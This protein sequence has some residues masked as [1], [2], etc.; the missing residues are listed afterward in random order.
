M[1]YSRR[2]VGRS[3]VLEVV[4]DDED[5]SRNATL[6]AS[7]GIKLRS[8]VFPRRPQRRRAVFRQRTGHTFQFLLGLGNG[9]LHLGDY[10]AYVTSLTEPLGLSSS[11]VW[12][13]I[14]SGSLPN[15]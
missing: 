9:T 12:S 15:Q 3:W 13:R 2:A 1:W 4:V 8:N 11:M 5:K 7:S 6:T 14:F 10:L